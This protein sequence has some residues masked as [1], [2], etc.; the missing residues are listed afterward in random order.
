MTL[1]TNAYSKALSHIKAYS[2]EC[3][4]L[5]INWLKIMEKINWNNLRGYLNIENEKY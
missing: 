1:A 3:F 5:W 2:L 4:V